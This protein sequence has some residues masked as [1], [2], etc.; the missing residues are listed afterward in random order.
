MLGILDVSM[1]V[2]NGEGK[3]AFTRLEKQLLANCVDESLFACITPSLGLPTHRDRGSSLREDEWGLL[4]PSPEPG[5]GLY[6][7]TKMFQDWNR[8]AFDRQQRQVVW[9]ADG[10]RLCDNTA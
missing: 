3:K 9:V 10:R 6:R 2:I 4:A 8:L 7:R 1:D 5:G